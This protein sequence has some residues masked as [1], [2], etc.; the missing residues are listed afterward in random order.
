MVAFA[1]IFDCEFL[2]TETARHRF[3]CGP[4]DPDPI[5][6]Q[7]GALRLDLSPPFEITGGTRIYIEPLDR[8]G[9]R[10]P[11]DPFFTRLTGIT[12]QDLDAQATSLADAL[13]KLETLSG[14]GRLWS[15]G[16]DE[17][18]LLAI[19]CF[20][21]GMPPPL[22]VQRF[23][24]ACSLMLRAGMPLDQIHVTSS[25]ALAT[26]VGLEPS[27]APGHDGLS[28]ATSVARGLQHMLRSERLS[29]SDFE[30]A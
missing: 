22:P 27:G 4:T 25:T 13:A 17:L 7:I 6:V 23:G 3:W 14:G 21:A 18:N 20:V 12:E 8:S 19:S 2:V 11:L 28:D 24:N 5:V 26:A 30:T 16:K 9:Q 15:W 29:A 1:T 10:I